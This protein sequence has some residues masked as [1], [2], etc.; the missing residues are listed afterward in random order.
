MLSR[1]KAA[2][3]A[4]FARVTVL[5]ALLS[6]IVLLA[7]AARSGFTTCLECAI[8]L[9]G[10]AAGLWWAG[11]Q[12]RRT[13]VVGV[14]VTLGALVGVVVVCLAEGLWRV[15][16]IA[17]GLCLAALA[18]AH[19]AG[20]LAGPSRPAPIVVRPRP[21]RPV[22]ILNP[23]S[24]GGKVAEFDLARQARLSGADVVLLD[25][26]AHQD[27]S[28]VARDAVAAGAD[29]LGVAGGDGTL[30][31]V[32]AVA[33]ENR[34]PFLVLPAGTR[35]HFA[36]DLG[37]DRDDPAAAL[38]ALTD[39]VEAR[40]DVGDVDGRAFVNTVSFGA[41]AETIQ[42]P[43]YRDDK[44]GTALDRLPAL[45]RAGGP[46][47]PLTAIADGTRLTGSQ[48]LLV[49]NN[50]YAT[51][52]PLLE[53]RRPRLDRGVLGVLT[54]RVDRP[55]QA[56]EAALRRSGAKPVTATTA[57]RVTVTGDAAQIPVGVDGEALTL[58][59]PV[60]CSIRPDAL[61]VL[62]PRYPTTRT[63]KSGLRQ[64]LRLAFGSAVR[65]SPAESHAVQSPSASVVELR[66]ST[67]DPPS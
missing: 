52:G 25:P 36:M 27:L 61:R 38:R 42:R 65:R 2:G 46:E 10:A 60:T 34:L 14:T 66:A 39:G 8:G 53:G 26:S 51:E 16:P 62:L 56:A 37:I 1:G 64:I 44:I 31:A 20:R 35:N 23:A 9:A 49:S 17:A 7:A 13:R 55:N 28:A 48:V 18:C 11:S 40:I 57:H 21:L 67:E 6:A 41:Y 59:T 22:L 50:P 24:G 33:A 29:L 12:R 19:R 15:L 63:T 58:P 30:A 45:L 43:E 3:A 4:L 54:V 5:C 47:T 32:A